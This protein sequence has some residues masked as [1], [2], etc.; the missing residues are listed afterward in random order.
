MFRWVTRFSCSL[1]LL[2]A[3]LSSATAQNRPL[4]DYRQYFKP[5]ETAQEFWKAIKFEI[6]LGAYP[7]AAEFLKGFLAKV[8]E[9]TVIEIENKD[10]M[11]SFL[12]LRTVPK[13]S[14]DPKINNEAKKNVEDLIESV[15]KTIKAHRTD[16]ERLGKLVD[17]LG[18]TR[19]ERVYAIAEL[20]RSG[21]DAMPFVV[22][23]LVEALG[24]DRFTNITSALPYLGRE[25]VPAL[26]A[27]LEHS[28]PV[29]RAAIVDVIRKRSDLAQL[30]RH[31]DSNP[32]PW[33]Y[34]LAYSTKQPDYLRKLALST[35][36]AIHQTQAEKLPPARTEITREANRFY[37]H[38]IRFADSNSIQLWKWDGKELT[39]EIGNA[40]RA[41]E[42]YG[43]RY[44]QL[45]LDLDPGYEP[46]QVVVLGLAVEKGLEGAGLDQPLDKL[47]KLKQ[48]LATVNADVLLA[49]L[50]RALD[51]QK[52]ATALGVLRALSERLEVRAKQPKVQ[53]QPALVRALNYP[54]RRVQFAA[55]DALL[56]LPG[57]PPPQ[58]TTRTVEVLRRTVESDPQPRVLIGD[59]NQ[60]RGLEVAKAV[61]EAGYDAVVVQTG[62]QLIQRLQQAA[63]IDAVIVDFELPDP[64]LRQ[65][66]ALLR[67]DMDMAQIPL[68]VTIPP[69]PRGVRPPDAIIPLER[70]LQPYRN[71]RIVEATNN[72][73]I[74]KPLL[75]ERIAAAMG[76]PF[77]EAERKAVAAEGMVWLRRLAGGEVPG[78]KANTAETAIL[79]ALR[80]EELQVLAVEAAGRLPGRE[81]Q[82]A[83]AQVVLDEA[84]RAEVRVLAAV[85]LARSIQANRAALAFTQAKGLENLFNTT[86]DRRIKANVGLV[87]G[88]L[89]P[90]IYKTGAQLKN[91][92]PEP[93]AKP[94]PGP[95]E[96]MDKEKMDKEKMEKEKE[97]KKE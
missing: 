1:A 75:D 57:S 37:N 97:E 23:E 32:V 66:V 10:G 30:T 73:E 65:L 51:E 87:L 44:A 74:L 29:V 64:M 52:T 13:W 5:P 59:F 82:R 83:L 20:R 18:A 28:S 41:E 19:G 34:Y 6:E 96:K 2:L 16:P 15:T 43:I 40:S 85:E 84:V 71:V 53:G 80:N 33:L 26:L 31:F 69:L 39:S 76:K 94:E 90:D 22:K 67:S 60:D 77:T 38:K 81:P 49:T 4:E 3:Y 86:E 89:R 58:G 27:T 63:D 61:K 8:D 95:K 21:T 79:K 48:L 11:S 56:R 24:T 46:A 72:P 12:F 68:F 50:E 62:K 35:L 93:A 54:D 55:A 92:V 47:P 70:M 42:A 88:A 9:K 36:E 45:A 14:D 78:F 25:S 7:V 91:F 17:L